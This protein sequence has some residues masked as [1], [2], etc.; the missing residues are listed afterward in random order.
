MR[1]PTPARSPTPRSLEDRVLE[2]GGLDPL[3]LHKVWS[4]EKDKKLVD[5]AR[6]GAVLAPLVARPE[7]TSTLIFTEDYLAG[8]ADCIFFSVNSP[9]PQMG[10]DNLCF[11]VETLDSFGAVGYRPFDLIREY[12]ELLEIG[13]NNPAYSR[14]HIPGLKEYL[15]EV[16]A[17]IGSRIDSPERRRIIDADSRTNGLREYMRGFANCFTI[18]GKE[19]ALAAIQFWADLSGT[20]EQYEEFVEEDVFREELMLQPW[21]AETLEHMRSFCLHWGPTAPPE[22][23]MWRLYWT[24][25]RYIAAN[26]GVFG[27]LLL[28]GSIPV[29]C[30]RG[31]A[32]WELSNTRMGYEPEPGS[33]VV[34]GE[35]VCGEGL[36]AFQRWGESHGGDREM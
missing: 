2:P 21:F 7:A 10:G 18:W 29:C 13:T 35:D 24:Q 9:V 26:I 27:E 23:W 14:W 8:D 33:V 5:F 25:S 12:R 16:N 30:A 32:R 1:C 34:F 11:D 22:D 19:P 20:I 4:R 28:K 15:D 3:A 6:Q 36:S 31:Y 17:R